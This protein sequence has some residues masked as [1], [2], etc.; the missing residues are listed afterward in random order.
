MLSTSVVQT[1][2]LTQ[3]TLIPIS[4]T[5]H[6]LN[7]NLILW[8]M[9]KL[10]SLHH[11]FSSHAWWTSVLILAHYFTRLKM[12]STNYWDH[13]NSWSKNSFTELHHS[14]SMNVMGMLPAWF[15]FFHI[16]ILFSFHNNY[17]DKLH[18]RNYN[19]DYSILKLQRRF[20]FCHSSN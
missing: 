18:N 12:K 1:M 2:M 11:N 7:W 9:R 13:Q 15:G 6:N 8:I 4:K 20:F 3:T 16:I 19:C 14:F 10:N 17:T 5:F